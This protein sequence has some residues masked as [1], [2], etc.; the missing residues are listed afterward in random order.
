MP[1]QRYFKDVAPQ[2][3]TEVLAVMPA[4]N[5]DESIAAIIQ[6]I[7][8][9]LPW[10]PILVVD[11]GSTD[12][13]RDISLTSGAQVLSMPFNV[14]VGGAMKAGFFFALQSGFSKVIQIDADG[15]HDPRFVTTLLSELKEA[16]IVIGARFAGVGNYSVRGPRRWAM[17]LLAKTMSRICRVPLTDATSGFK[18][19]GPRALALFATQYPTEYLGD[20]VEA[21]AL[22]ARHGLIVKQIPVEMRARF[23][24][25][26]SQNYMKS[27][28]YLF[29]VALALFSALNSPKKTLD[30]GGNQ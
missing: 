20:T 15:Q 10:I 1:E 14:G 2:L 4:L 28:I 6:E 26:P 7:K 8:H 27:T 22:A 30:L 29:R 3:S 11:D 21:L 17:S 19:M 9:Q 24:G 18:A 12:R 16:D 5:E 13:T 23:G 25:E